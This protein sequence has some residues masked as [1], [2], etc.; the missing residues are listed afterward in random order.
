[1]QQTSHVNSYRYLDSLNDPAPT[2]F[3]K[4]KSHFHFLLVEPFVSYCF[5]HSTTVVLK[6]SAVLLKYSAVRF[7][8]LFLTPN[9]TGC[10]YFSPPPPWW[11]GCGFNYLVTNYE[12]INSIDRTSRYSPS[13][14]V[15]KLVHNNRMLDFVGIWTPKKASYTF[16]ADCS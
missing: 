8:N 5:S 10:S 4:T 7:L 14:L 13:K 6:Y 1:M 16:R 11:G 15:R 3:L 12:P 2:G 9:T